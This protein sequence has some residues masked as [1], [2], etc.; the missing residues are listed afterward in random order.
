MKLELKD[1]I[2]RYLS[3]GLDEEQSQELSM[4]L[5]RS[6]EARAEF[7]ALTKVH[8]SLADHFAEDD[9]ARFA[10]I[11]SSIERAK[12]VVTLRSIAV[13]AALFVGLLAIISVLPRG[14]AEKPIAEI[15]QDEAEW[16]GPIG[17]FLDKGRYEILTGLAELKIGPGVSLAIEGPALFRLVDR[18]RIEVSRGRIAANVTESGKG[19][20]VVTPL[21]EI[22]DLGTRFGVRVD[23]DGS[24][25]AHVFEGE[26]DLV[27]GGKSQRLSDTEALRLGETVPFESDPEAFPMPS[28]RL[29]AG[30]NG[31][32]FEPGMSL[33]SGM[34]TL[35]GVWGGDTS[36]IVPGFGEIQPRAGDGML[37]FIAAHAVD[38]ELQ[39][40]VASELW[41]I[42]DL[43]SFANRV[44][45]GEVRARLSA[46]FNR[47]PGTANSQFAVSMMAFRGDP[48]ETSFYWNRKNETTSERLASSSSSLQADEEPETWE[49]LRTGFVVPAGTDF[50]VVNLFATQNASQGSEAPFGGHFLD[51]AS[52]VLTAEARPS[53]PKSVWLG[54]AGDWRKSNH[55]TEGVVP[56]PQRDHIVILGDGTAEIGGEIQLKQ[57]L[58]IAKDRNSQGH[59]LIKKGGRLSKSG[60]GNLVVGYNEGAEGILTIQ[61]IF[62]SREEVYIGRNN[63]KSLVD[64]DGGTWEAGDGVIRMAQY[65]DRGPDTDARLL[66]R[67]G[68]RLT[69]GRLG[70]VHDLA[71]FEIENGEAEVG[72]LQ[73]G[74]DNG[75]AEVRLGIG[76]LQVEQLRFGAS[77]GEFVFEKEDSEL[78]LAGKWTVALLRD[79]PGA[80]WKFQSRDLT[81]FH[82]EF[83]E[84]NGVEFTR[85]R[86]KLGP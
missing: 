46:H 31:A 29:S 85:I 23:D 1:L 86:P 20:T 71:T 27:Q 78:W 59:L 48:R 73:I 37:R 24:C 2:E 11:S 70:L 62:E 18:H 40:H 57:S 22:I 65:G 13:L 30:L 49:Q 39:G 32:D 14:S 72:V 35:P 47:L 83:G 77:N 10:P 21:G 8:V 25:E 64:I 26:I 38:R 41:Q 54:E 7:R 79:L 42:V 60:Y 4:L 68:G 12:S 75:K 6:P 53:I 61:G 84:N 74:G 66:I 55:W 9:I 56:D 34:P 69:V 52:L 36:E 45:A 82:L 67:N 51:Q 80:N 43:R 28:H 19:F 76:K 33:G 58:I 81:D 17:A 16:S 63:A 5:E 44:N 50:L 3:E 15:V